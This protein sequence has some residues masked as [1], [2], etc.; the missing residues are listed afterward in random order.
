MNRYIG[1]SV[2]ATAMV[3]GA[4]AFA[5]NA[6]SQPD[7]NGT[8]QPPGDETAA[9]TIERLQSQGPS[10]VVKGA[11]DGPLEACDVEDVTSGEQE[12]TMIVTVACD[13]DYAG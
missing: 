1:T 7:E 10:V 13:P 12:T 11:V 3:F 8:P 9:A 2:A 5:G 4:V 6:W